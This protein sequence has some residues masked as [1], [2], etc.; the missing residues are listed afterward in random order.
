MGT[1]KA[2]SPNS[3]SSFEPTLT[4]F[5]YSVVF[6]EVNSE[7]PAWPL[8]SANSGREPRI[9]LPSRYR[10]KSALRC[11]PKTAVLKV[12]AYDLPAWKDCSAPSV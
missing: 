10:P 3:G 11:G 5:L 7:E 8:P 12:F 1:L 2:F 9:S 4:P 6:T